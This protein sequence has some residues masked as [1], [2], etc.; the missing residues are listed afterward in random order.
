MNEENETTALA[1]RDHGRL[2]RASEVE[3]SNFMPLMSIEQA[4]E[5]KKQINQFISKVLV[6]KHDYGIIPGTNDKKVLLKPG[7]EKMSS[8]FGLAPKYVKETIIEDWTGTTSLNS[9]NMCLI[10]EEAGAEDFF[11][12]FL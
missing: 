10:K 1:T 8:I 9:T 3:A 2:I 7:A 4:I 11:W 12:D 6:D 5:R